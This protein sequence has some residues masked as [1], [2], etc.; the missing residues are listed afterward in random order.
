MMKKSDHIQNG[1]NEMADIQNLT[2]LLADAREK[3]YA[4]G[5]FSARYTKL[6]R[7]I[8]QAAINT[9][10]PV[11]VQLSEK[12]VIRHKVG[13]KEFADEFYRVAEELDPQIPLSLHL[14]HTKTLDVIK[15][16]LE[17]GF[18]SVMIDASEKDFDEN[19]AITQRVMEMAE[20]YHATVEAELGKIGTTDFAETDTDEELYTNPEE[21]AEFCRLTGVDCL[22]VSVGTAHGVYTVRQPKVDYERLETINRLTDTPLV[23]HGG[24]G[25]PS[26][27]VVKAAQIPTGGVS[28][29]N[30]ATDIELAMLAVIGREGHM[31]EEELNA[32]TAEQIEKSRKAVRLLVEDKIRNYLLSE[33]RA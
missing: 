1:E 19:T 17:A 9:N 28:K 25:V 6:I 10:S 7:P 15:E 8:I 31:T 29:V 14:D 33:N 22:A 3:G 12:E 30:I 13:I 24:S 20:P 5:S 26:E 32:C 23:L 18:T 21:A 11:I 27:M 2:K 4:V 16:A